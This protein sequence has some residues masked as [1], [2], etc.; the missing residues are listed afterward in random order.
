MVKRFSNRFPLFRFNQKRA[1]PF[2]AA[3]LTPI[4]GNTVP[5]PAFTSDKYIIK[6]A[7]LL[8]ES[9]KMTIQ[10]SKMNV[11]PQINKRDAN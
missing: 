11:V 5:P 6:V 8:P 3:E 9:I 1:D 2:V 10:F 7:N 4:T